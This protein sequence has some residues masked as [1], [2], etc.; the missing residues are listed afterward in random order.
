MRALPALLV[1]ALLFGVALP[2]ATAGPIGAVKVKQAVVEAY[3][4]NP[5]AQIAQIVFY[6]QGEDISLTRIREGITVR[7]PQR[8]NRFTAEAFEVDTTGFFDVVKVTL[9]P[10]RLFDVGEDI[11]FVMTIPG[12]SKAR[13]VLGEIRSGPIKAGAL[14]AWYSNDGKGPAGTTG[15]EV[16]PR[17]KLGGF[18]VVVN[19]A[20]YSAFNDLD[21][22]FA[23]ED[24]RFFPNMTEAQFD[25]L[26]LHQIFADSP[27]ESML[28]IPLP[29]STADFTGLP[30]PDFG[31][32]FIAAGRM[33]D[34]SGHVIGAFANGVQVEAIPVPEPSTA[35]LLGSAIA[36]VWARR[37][38]HRALRG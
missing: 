17:P 10:L 14:P 4:E 31:N 13:I 27:D 16:K 21:E 12:I 30:D 2:L 34:S 26:D 22:P 11:S 23:I 35:L 28:D 29:W 18:E 15:A 38:R 36:A 32:L 37:T 3:L 8:P 5:G 25:A 20:G 19:D 9:V 1:S 24:L 33:R 7:S 6:L